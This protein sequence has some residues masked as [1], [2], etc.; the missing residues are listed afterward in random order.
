LEDRRTFVTLETERT[1][2]VQSLMFII[3]IIIIIIIIT[4][5]STLF[6]D[7][8]GNIDKLRLCIRTVVRILNPLPP[9][10]RIGC[11]AMDGN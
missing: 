1:K 9:E 3:I 2:L 11:C 10:Y 6:P 5:A 4:I 8:Q 7:S